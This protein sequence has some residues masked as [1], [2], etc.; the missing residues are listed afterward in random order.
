[1]F[2]L[3]YILTT[4]YINTVR[5]IYRKNEAHSLSFHCSAIWC[6]RQIKRTCVTK[7]NQQSECENAENP[8]TCLVYFSGSTFIERTG[9]LRYPNHGR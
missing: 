7:N 5:T 6:F 2:P 8:V 4:L 3:A 1:M 9:A